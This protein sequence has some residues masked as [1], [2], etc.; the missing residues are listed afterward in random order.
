MGFKSKTITKLRY[1]ASLAAGLTHLMINQKDA[2]GLI[3]FDNEIKKYIPPR[4]SNTHKSIIY[5]SLSGCKAGKNTDI[6]SIL[7]IMAERIKKR[8]LVIIISDLFTKKGK[9]EQKTH[10]TFFPLRLPPGG[11]QF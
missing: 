9:I 1:G 11:I 4:T 3:L 2:V 10:E 7:D 8:G 6:R 5:N